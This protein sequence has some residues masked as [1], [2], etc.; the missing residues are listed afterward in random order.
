MP[1]EIVS[2]P[3]HLPPFWEQ[4]NVLFFSNIHSIFYDNVR[5]TEHLLRAIAGATSYG[6]RLLGIIDLLYRGANNTVFLESRPDA[7]LVSYLENDLG[8]SIPDFTIINAR[9]YDMFREHHS[10]T[11]VLVRAYQEHPAEWVDG[12]V[13]DTGLSR[14]AALLDK[15]TVSSVRGSKRGNNKYLLHQH[16]A[17]QGL[18]TFDTFMASGR[19]ELTPCLEKLE[20]LGYPKAVIKSQ[21][22]ASGFGMEM[23]RTRNPDLAPVGDYLFFEGPCM[24]QGWLNEEVPGV[25]HLGS[26]SVQFFVADEQVFLFDI[27]EQVLS[28]GSVHQGNV[29]PPLYLEH[30]PDLQLELLRQASVAAAWIHD[31]GYRGTA[32]ADFLLVEQDACIRAIVCEVNARVT[33][34]TY[35]SL[36]ARHF[37]P[38]HSWIMRNIRFRRPVASQ[39]LLSLMKRTGLLYRSGTASGILPFNF[40]TDRDHRVIKG[41]FLFLG[42]THDDCQEA[43]TRAESALHVGWEYDRD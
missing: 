2:T 43:L 32:S 22:G 28:D 30:Q 40:N 31:Q 42:E 34:A 21:I 6:G 9:T 20:H 13:T 38:G 7:G 33:G 36:L 24:V 37:N 3:G 25:R 35:P 26:P 8:L 14:I 41:Q 27:T 10:R 19:H 12:Y 23:V 1:V 18:P 11:E 4:R 5:E 29:A 16:L 15:R 17:H 39:L